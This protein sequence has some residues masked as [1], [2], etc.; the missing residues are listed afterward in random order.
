MSFCSEKEQRVWSD[1]FM[2]DV[3]LF[4][5]LCVCVCAAAGSET[6]GSSRPL[7][8]DG[9]CQYGWTRTLKGQCK[10]V[11]EAGCK[12]GECVGPDQCRC[13]PGF[14]GKTCN[15]AVCEAG[16]KHGECVGPDQCRCHPGFTGK[17]CNQG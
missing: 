7:L 14:T 10:P 13:H 16:C 15:Q 8:S 12:H 1:V 3:A 11:C 17:T 2:M 6:L 4:L 9:L 5:S